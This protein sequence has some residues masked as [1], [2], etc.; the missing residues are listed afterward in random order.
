M[1][2]GGASA[3]RQG[4]RLAVLTAAIAGAL[5]GAVLSMLPALLLGLVTMFYNGTGGIL[6]FLGSLIPALPHPGGVGHGASA[7]PVFQ[8]L[9]SNP[10]TVI[11][12]SVAATALCAIAAASMMAAYRRERDGRFWLV[13]GVC[14][15]LA[16]VG[17]GRLVAF[18]VMP[19]VAASVGY[20]VQR[21]MRR[22]VRLS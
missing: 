12:R 3:S 5:A 4:L 6:I 13:A 19:A 15:V 22:G 16:A 17:G 8:R 11:L 20:L 21:T 10:T 2:P 18:C 14:G 9:D 7:L 1:P